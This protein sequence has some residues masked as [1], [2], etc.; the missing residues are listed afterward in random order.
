MIQDNLLL[1]YIAVWGW[2]NLSFVS[3]IG[4]LIVLT[5]PRSNMSIAIFAALIISC[6]G[7]FGMVIKRKKELINDVSE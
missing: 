1:N 2:L 3:L 7:C 4:G 6:L 5:L